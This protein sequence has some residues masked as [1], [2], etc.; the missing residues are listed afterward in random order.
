[1]KTTI[2]AI[3]FFIF[4]G[5]GMAQDLQ[6]EIHGKYTRGVS[7]EKLNTAKTMIDIRP[8]YPSTMI[9]DYISTHISVTTSG[10]VKKATGDNETLNAEQ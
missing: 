3:L 1:M 10:K 8:G 4:F 9:D 7:K 5:L 6:Y 2:T